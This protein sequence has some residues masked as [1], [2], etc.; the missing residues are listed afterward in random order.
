MGATTLSDEELVTSHELGS[1]A[2]FYRAHV[3]GLLGALTRAQFAS[4]LTA[5]G[6]V[7]VE[8]VETHRVHTQAGSAIV[9]ANA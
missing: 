4:A 8:I 6:L 3:D 5:A 1:F 7:D 9:R 2:L